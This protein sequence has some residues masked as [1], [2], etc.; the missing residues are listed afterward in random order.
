[1]KYTVVKINKS[2]TDSLKTANRKA[3]DK[4]KHKFLNKGTIKEAFFKKTEQL[5]NIPK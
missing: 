5:G 4:I 2:Q 3:P 1:M